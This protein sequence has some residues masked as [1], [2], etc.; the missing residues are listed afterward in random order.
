[1]IQDRAAGAIIGGLIGDALGLGCHWYYDLDEMRRDHGNWIGD[2]TTPKPDR[3]HAG[4]RAG[5]LSQTGLI[6]VML[7]RSVIENK[8]YREDDFTRRLDAELFPQLD[9]TAL[10]GPGGYTNQSIREAYQRRVVEKKLWHE[11]GSRLADTTEAAERAVVLAARYARKPHRAAETTFSNCLLT[12]TNEIVT[13][14]STAFA[15]IVTQLIA[16]EKFD[17]A[18]P[19][20]LMTLVKKGDL[21]FEDPIIPPPPGERL[22]PTSPLFAPDPLFLATHAVLAANDP[23]VQIEP[24]WKA[25]LVF[26]L[27][28]PIHHQL[29]AAYYLAARFPD[30]FESAVLHAINGGGQNMS[31]AFLTGTLV[32]AQVGLSRI[33][34]RFID[35]LENGRELVALARQLAELA[36]VG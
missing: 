14:L 21:L 23:G 19:D 26:G 9:G 27:P 34:P 24:A 31:R 33:P 2:Y 25:S 1:M 5:Q 32:G 10:V 30:D 20:K 18:L 4:M 6:T 28:C 3:Y 15:C 8:E 22:L 17:L 29:P 35:G 13:A 12:Q 16:G 7:L 11:T 36:E